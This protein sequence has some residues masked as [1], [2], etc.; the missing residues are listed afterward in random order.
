MRGSLESLHV[1]NGFGRK[2]WFDV[3]T[4]NIFPQG[5]LIT[6][7][8]VGGGAE[9]GGIGA[10]ARC[11]WG[12]GLSLCSEAITALMGAWAGPRLL[13]QTPWVS[14]LLAQLPL[15]L[16]SSPSQH[17]HPNSREAQNWNKR[18]WCGYS[19]WVRQGLWWSDHFQRCR[20][21]LMWHLCNCQYWPP[22]PYS[23][24]D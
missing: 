15:S 13:D 7:T 10:R 23:D 3:N 21:P 24:T 1:P 9:D 5:V 16:C 20:M 12:E 4:S 6:I 22:L 17:Q 11:V 8:F 2:H 19:V 14:G 18:S